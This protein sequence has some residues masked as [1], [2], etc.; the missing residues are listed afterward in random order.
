VTIL[1]SGESLSHLGAFI[2]REAELADDNLY[3]DWL[4]LWSP[5]DAFYY[6]PYDQSEESS[7]RVAVIRDD[8][9]RLCERI[10]R[11]KGGQTHTQNPPSKLCRVLGPLAFEQAG[12]P[13]LYTVWT[14]FICVEVRPDRQVT[15]A[16]KVTYR[17]RDQ[18]PDRIE[19]HRKIVHLV[20]T[21][22]PIPALSFII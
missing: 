14:R 11:L 18:G 6:V 3:D 19:L 7:K 9:E 1:Q 10:N 20:N 13:D 17:L 15:W 12:S 2:L 4:G 5:Q 8:Y 21:T 22:R 16:G